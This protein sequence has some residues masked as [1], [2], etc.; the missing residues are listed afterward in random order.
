MSFPEH[1][2]A[3]IENTTGFDKESFIEVHENVVSIT[4][5]RK[6]ERKIPL[7]INPIIETNATKVPWCAA[8]SYL[9]IR[10]IFVLDPLWHVG[11]YYVQEAS[12]MFIDHI[13]KTIVP[14]PTNEVVLDLCAAPGGKTTLLLNH[15][16]KGLVV[17]NETIKN[18]NQIL[19]ENVTK[20]GAQNVVVTQNDPAQFS[21]VAQFFDVVLVDAPC[22][23]SGL[24]RRD[25]DA[26][27]EWSVDHV[28]HCSVR[29]KES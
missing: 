27:K 28:L 21:S 17:A 15:F 26:M 9:P 29:Q 22:S 23:G 14:N 4:S 8:G 6:N 24:F 18:R 5:I 11:A 2:I 12:S 20:W 10:P 1:F 7:E 13:V 3:S 19:V 25:P 16:Q